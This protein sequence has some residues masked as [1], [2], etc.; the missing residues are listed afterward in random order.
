MASFRCPP[1]CPFSPGIPAVAAC[2]HLAACPP[3]GPAG[4]I[5]H[6]PTSWTLLSAHLQVTGVLA[7]A[8]PVLAA[9]RSTP[10][11][12]GRLSGSAGSCEARGSPGR[13]CWLISV[14]PGG[15]KQVSLTRVSAQQGEQRV[16]MCPRVSEGA[17]GRLCE[18]PPVPLG[19]S[20]LPRNSHR[21]RHPVLA[22][23]WC[24]ELLLHLFLVLL[25]S[26]LLGE[27]SPS[28]RPQSGPLPLV[29]PLH[30]WL[31]QSRAQDPEGAT[32]SPTPPF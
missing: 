15:R 26:G 6:S 30:P 23:P 8:G 29:G 18:Q 20:L 28:S 5:S 31:P 12:R 9:G 25:P 13:G 27:A 19:K 3:R 11:Q 1:V 24:S 14:S 22:P 21:P 17:L 16:P 2:S 32:G 4:R 10:G 7:A